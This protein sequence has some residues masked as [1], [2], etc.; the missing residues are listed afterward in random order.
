MRTDHVFSHTTAASLWGMPLPQ[1]LD[2]R[3]VH[4]S[5]TAPARAPSGKTITGHSVTL[6]TGDIRELAGVRVTSPAATWAQLSE[7]LELYDVVAVADFVITGN[8]FNNVLP[9]ATLEELEGVQ[10]ARGSARGRRIR[11]LALPMVQEGPLSRP[12]SVLRCVL[13]RAGA[14][15]PQMNPSILDARGSF[16]A[17]P[18]LAWPQFSFAIEY[19][20]D[21]HR[22]KGQFRRDIRRI[23]RLVDA[24]WSVMKVSADDLFDRPDE[25]A[26]RALRRLGGRGWTRS[27]RELRQVGQ[28]R[29]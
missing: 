10:L 28:I 14:P 6:G 15:L 20:G 27:S 24:G 17:M 19:E 23:E 12:E 7:S 22:E 13:V 9:L 29:R 3:S 4:V 2:T 18:D 1:Y 25:T 8:P 21:H 5:A 16:I 26:E 11:V